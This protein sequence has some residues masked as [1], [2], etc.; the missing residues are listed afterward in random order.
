MT[1]AL[2]LESGEKQHWRLNEELVDAL[3]YADELPPAWKAQVDQLIEEEM[4]RS[5]KKPADF[6]ELL[7]P[8]PELAFKD[9]PALK[10]EYLRVAAGQPIKPLDMSRYQMEEPPLAKKNDVKAWEKAVDNARTQIEHQHVRLVNLELLAKFGS[11]SYRVSNMGLESSL[12]VQEE[13]LAEVKKDVEALN[14]DRKLNQLAAGG[15]IKRL[16]AQ[17]YGLVDKN[18]DIALGCKQLEEE[19]A[20]L[21]EECTK[22]GLALPHE[23]TD[24]DMME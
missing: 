21:R 12:K 22:K 3:P 24:E 18:M 11:N 17:W 13:L 10:A 9:A 20:K 19:V 14:R 1:P 23:V 7:P 5:R 16:E 8:A 4:R 2:L 6:L 15:E